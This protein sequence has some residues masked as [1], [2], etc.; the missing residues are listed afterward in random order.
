MNGNG[1]KPSSASLKGVLESLLFVAEQ[2]LTPAKL[3]E[4]VGESE[5]EVRQALR[6]LADEYYAGDR[7]IQVREVAGGYRL[8][9]HPAN[10][11]YIERLFKIAEARRLS[12][13]AL[14]TLSIVAYKQPV[15]RLEI[16]AIRGVNSDGAV[17]TLIARGLIR[18]VGRERA[19]GNPI[20]YGTA[21]RFLEVFGLRN[22]GD[23]PPI[24]DFEPD[25]QAKEQIERTL[26]T[27]PAVETSDEV[28]LDP[29]EPIEDLLADGWPQ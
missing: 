25:E 27:E 3:A 26:R 16:S 1:S 13:A 22:L 14:E 4:A 12:Q 20:L 29:A 15:T 24:K 7:G 9:T 19:P 2:P 10:A 21:K 11:S 18:E 6:E 5:A 23:L 8:F 17:S 28:P